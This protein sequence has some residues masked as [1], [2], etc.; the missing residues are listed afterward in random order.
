MEL[1][2][3]NVPQMETRPSALVFS[4]ILFNSIFTDKSNALILV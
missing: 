2:E 4:H 1:P 3:A